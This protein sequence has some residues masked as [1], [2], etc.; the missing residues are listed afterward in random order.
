[1]GK[2]WSDRIT[3][4]VIV[5]VIFL[6]IGMWVF[7]IQSCVNELHQGGGIKPALSELWCGTK[8]CL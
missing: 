7:S 3:V 5:L 4:F 2:K 1:M 6:F 8:E